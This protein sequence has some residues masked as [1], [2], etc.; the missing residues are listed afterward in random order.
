MARALLTICPPLGL[1]LR[2]LLPTLPLGKR[3]FHHHQGPGI[4][5]PRLHGQCPPGQGGDP[6]SRRCPRPP[7]QHLMPAGTGQ[8]QDQAPWSPP[9]SGPQEVARVAEALLQ[10]SA[11]NSRD[12]TRASPRCLD[13]AGGGSSELQGEG[14]VRGGELRA[15]A[16]AWP[17][18]EM[19]SEGGRQSG[20]GFTCRL[21]AMCGP[22][23]SS[24]AWSG[25]P[26][27]G[28]KGGELPIGIWLYRCREQPC[29]GGPAPFCFSFHFPTT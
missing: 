6:A 22:G 7:H 24:R 8:P 11:G 28:Q 16:G 27:E 13:E 1:H 23:G 17:K 2:I 25:E 19:G 15:T 14:E 10:E 9:F 20:Q 26:M 21:G 12:L 29:S 18:P 4:S 3:L 5:E